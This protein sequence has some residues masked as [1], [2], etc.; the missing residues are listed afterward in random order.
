MP[1]LQFYCGEL[2]VGGFQYA[3]VEIIRVGSVSVLTSLEG[4]CIRL[5]ESPDF[6]EFVIHFVL[7]I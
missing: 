1:L 2:Y 7:I 3:T 4:I 6:I 5:M